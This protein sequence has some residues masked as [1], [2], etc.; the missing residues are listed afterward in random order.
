M[1]KFDTIVL[2]AGLTGMSFAYH[3]NRSVPLFER[4]P[5]PGG[6]ARTIS[7]NGYAFDLAP[8]LLHMRSPYL[9][10]LVFNELNLDLQ[11][12][13]RHSVIYFDSR[14]VP[15]PFELHLNYLSEKKR[16][17][18]LQGIEELE[19]RDKKEDQT[20]QAESYK[21]YALNAFG[22]GIARNY[23]LPYNR[24]VWDI[25][26]AEM[27]C[28]W[29]KLIPTV[30]LEQI[31]K[32]AFEKTEVKFGYNSEFYYPREN[33]VQALADAFAERLDNIRLAEEVIKIN[34]QKRVVY[35]ASNKEVQYQ[36]L[37]STIPL[38]QLMD[39]TDIPEL[40]Q[41]AK[42][43]RHTSV[44]MVNLVI[45]GDIPD[46]IHWMYFP[47]PD[48][49]FY[50]ISFP[51][52]YFPG[53]APENEKVLAVEVG[54]QNHDLALDEI[55]KKIIEQIQKIPVFKIRE[56]C[57]IHCEKIPVAYCIYDKFRTRI[58]NETLDILNDS[59]IKSIGRYGQWEYSTME[60]AILY[61]KELAEEIIHS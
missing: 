39:K 7:A 38:Q 4:N 40:H 35:F 32:N 54:S 8:H 10:S 45:K 33:G 42:K 3:F 17:E 20:F 12:Y 25:N 9:K 18:C 5:I 46:T 56:I 13:I 55:Q 37:V 58:V 22:K 57:L 44:Y 43:L 31:K 36:K 1:E 49:E 23:L 16:K 52:N 6:L 50:R 60:D 53:C 28:E 59:G 14:I 61:G 30:N 27:T 51:K 24:K 41:K 47:Q 48:F 2:G 29:M 15:Y 19:K 11:K 26:P 21:K 34:T